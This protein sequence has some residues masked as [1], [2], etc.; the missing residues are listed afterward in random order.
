MLLLL[1]Q[2]HLYAVRVAALSSSKWL[3]RTIN[4]YF[5]ISR[6][7]LLFYWILLTYFANPSVEPSVHTHA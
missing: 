3:R 1:I 4:Y 2:I 7:I 5:T 6:F